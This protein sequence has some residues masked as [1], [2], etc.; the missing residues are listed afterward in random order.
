MTKISQILV[1]VSLF[2]LVQ[3]SN[4]KYCSPASINYKNKRDFKDEISKNTGNTYNKVSCTCYL[5]F[6]DQADKKC[7]IGFKEVEGKDEPDCEYVGKV[8]SKYDIQAQKDNKEKYLKYNVRM[9]PYF[10]ELDPANHGQPQISKIIEST[11]DGD[12]T[13]FIGMTLEI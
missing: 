2:Y 1:I 10:R 13:E 8:Y 4:E 3:S 6:S 7:K 11:D 12:T 9:R 5:D